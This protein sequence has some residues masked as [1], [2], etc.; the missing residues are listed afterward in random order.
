M[1]VGG[2]E[3]LLIDIANEQAKSQT[4]IVIVIN[5]KVDGSIMNRLG[6]DVE[7]IY[8]NRKEGSKR[9]VVFLLKLWYYLLKLRPAII[10]CHNHNIISVLVGF[11]RKAAITVHDV[12]DP[13]YNLKKFKK[14]FS[15]SN[16]VYKDLMKSN[17][18]SAIVKNGINFS[19][20]NRRCEYSFTSNET[21]RIVQV[22]RLMHEKKGQDILLKAVGKLVHEIGFKNIAVDFIGTGKSEEYLTELTDKVRITDF[23]RFKKTRDRV[24]IQNNLCSYHLL[25]QPSRY[26]GFGLTV[27]EAIAAGIPVAASD[28]DGPA[29]ILKEMPSGYLFKT[30]DVGALALQIIEVYNHY[31]IN[32]I[33]AACNDS[34]EVAFKKYSIEQTAKAYVKNY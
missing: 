32:K 18:K 5:K 22:S 3:N 28:I 14:V 19:F 34:Y 6:R 30:E 20:F 10:H 8:L 11:K 17:I 16:A 31:K 23:A 1:G 9:N 33:E 21:F 27:V 15:I 29:E 12:G 26:E 13:V 25:V 7:I 4:V 2:A 24:W